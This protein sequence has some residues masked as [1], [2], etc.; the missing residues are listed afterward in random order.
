V[1]NFTR[2]FRGNAKSPLSLLC[3]M[4]YRVHSGSRRSAAVILVYKGR[5]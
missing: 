1:K 3:P 5:G 4:H 2:R